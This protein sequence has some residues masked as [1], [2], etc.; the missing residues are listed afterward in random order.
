MHHD[1]V[2]VLH[3][4]SQM[5]SE[6]RIEGQSRGK[7]IGELFFGALGLTILETV[8]NYSKNALGVKTRSEITMCIPPS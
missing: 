5:K 6:I 7:R 4:L 2:Q 8:V 1:G 3:C